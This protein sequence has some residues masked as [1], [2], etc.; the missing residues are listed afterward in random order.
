MLGKCFSSSVGKDAE[1]H[2]FPPP[3]IGL[4]LPLQGLAGRIYRDAPKWLNAAGL[5]VGMLPLAY[6]RG[7]GAATARARTT[8][9]HVFVSQLSQCLDLHGRAALCLTCS[10][11][12]RRGACIEPRS[13]PARER[14][15]GLTGV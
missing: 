7:M 1:I 12:Q 6:P 10:L 3:C 15:P 8:M 9:Q 14:V 13:L 11:Q 5:Q 4:V 2:G